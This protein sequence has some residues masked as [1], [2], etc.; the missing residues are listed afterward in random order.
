MSKKKTIQDDL[1]I[2]LVS[3]ST[4]LVAGPYVLEFTQPIVANFIN[5]QYQNPFS[6]GAYYLYVGGC[7]AAPFTFARAWMRRRKIG[8]ILSDGAA[9]GSA[10]IPEQNPAPQNDQNKPKR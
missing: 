4:A 1:P 2:V 5:N 6:A 9:L 10:F 7:W 3:I 8:K